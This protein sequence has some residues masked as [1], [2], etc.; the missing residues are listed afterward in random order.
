M[1]L[2]TVFLTLLALCA[3]QSKREVA[4]PQPAPDEGVHLPRPAIV[5]KSAAAIPKA[6]V[7]KT[8]GDFNNHVFILMDEA[9]N[10]ISYPAPSDVSSAS[11][12]LLL[13]D[14]WLL[15]RRGVAENAV[16][17]TYT[18]EQFHNLPST[19]S[20]PE[21]KS[22]IISGARV[23]QVL[24]LPCTLAQAEADTSAVNAWIVAH[25]P[26]AVL[27]RSEE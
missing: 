3:C 8:S 12:P 13:A 25:A 7:Y 19:P 11:A 5:E 4:L 23:T 18:W 2:L 9:G 17:L 15:D 22:H 26:K 14:G 21:L 24:Q 1:K 20:L 10:V 27:K 6:L 16:F